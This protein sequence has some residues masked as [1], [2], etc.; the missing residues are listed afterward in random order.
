VNGSLLKDHGKTKHGIEIP[1][2]F[3]SRH[4]G[5]PVR[6]AKTSRCIAVGSFLLSIAV[7]LGKFDHF[8]VDSNLA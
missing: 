5:I 2:S 3:V 6:K 1:L 8:F 7:Q 4:D